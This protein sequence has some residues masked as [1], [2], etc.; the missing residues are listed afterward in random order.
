MYAN[1]L[2]GPQPH[3]H[4]LAGLHLLHRVISNIY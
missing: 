4:S 2:S 1:E 3:V